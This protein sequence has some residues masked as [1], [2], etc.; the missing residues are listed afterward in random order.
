MNAVLLGI[1]WNL[2]AFARVFK[3][4]KLKCGRIVRHGITVLLWR[5]TSDKTAAFFIFLRTSVGK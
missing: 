1:V 4:E 3:S 2:I 5:K